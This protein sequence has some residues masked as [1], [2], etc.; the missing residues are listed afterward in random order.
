MYEILYVLAILA[1][2]LLCDWTKEDLFLA[3]FA[4]GFMI[5]GWR[6]ESISDS[7]KNME[8]KENKK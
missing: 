2:R 4:M 8:E 6:L 7:L 5:V 1:F 3:M